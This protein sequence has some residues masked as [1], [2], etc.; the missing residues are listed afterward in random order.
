[1]TTYAHMIQV[2][3]DPALTTS[4][5]LH[6]LFK[7]ADSWSRDRAFQDFNLSEEELDQLSSQVPSD[8]VCVA[9]DGDGQVL[10]FRYPDGSYHTVDLGDCFTISFDSLNADELTEYW[11][12]LLST[13]DT[14][15]HFYNG[16]FVDS[17]LEASFLE[18][19]PQ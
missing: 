18:S 17:S 2:S 15:L 8:A 10:T 5:K 13:E 12:S 3:R 7:D 11:D 9:H 1:M 6:E 19:F 4:Q 16:G 14:P